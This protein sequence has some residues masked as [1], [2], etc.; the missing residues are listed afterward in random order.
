MYYFEYWQ[1]NHK[2]IFPMLV[3]GSCLI[4]LDGAL[5]VVEWLMPDVDSY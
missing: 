4:S 5:P 1:S 3:A 2:Q